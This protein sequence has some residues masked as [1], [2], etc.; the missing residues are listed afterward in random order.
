MF[1]SQ[2]LCLLNFLPPLQQLRAI[3]SLI[4]LDVLFME[5]LLW[6]QKEQKNNKRRNDC[7]K[8]G[9]KHECGVSSTYNIANL[10]TNCLSPIL[11]QESVYICICVHVNVC[12]CMC[13]HMCTGCAHRTVCACAHMGAFV[14]ACVQVHAHEVFLFYVSF[15]STSPMGLERDPAA[16]STS[17]SSRETEF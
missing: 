3:K 12:A 9:L 11:R 7:Q 10:I 2:L 1:W 5:T 15:K 16:E 13:L 4:P 17:C 6:C 8:Q 14:C